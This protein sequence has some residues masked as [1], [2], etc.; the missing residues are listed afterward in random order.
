[1]ACLSLGVCKCTMG[2]LMREKASCS[3]SDGSV[4]DCCRKRAMQRKRARIQLPSITHLCFTMWL[5]LRHFHC[6][7]NL[8]RIR[9]GPLWFQKVSGQQTYCFK[10]LGRRLGNTNFNFM[11][12][13]LQLLSVPCT[14]VTAITKQNHP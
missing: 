9:Q 13:T 8:Y 7:N 4:G 11:G 12:K 10:N 2:L 1:M 3:S 6:F 5:Q 14:L